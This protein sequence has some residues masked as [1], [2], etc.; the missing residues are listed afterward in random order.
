MAANPQVL[1]FPCQCTRWKPVGLIRYL[2]LWVWAPSMEKSAP[3]ITHPT[4]LRGP[5]LNANNRI[6]AS[7]SPDSR[8]RGAMGALFM[9]PF[10]TGPAALA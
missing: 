3:L 7:P 6:G 5:G 4:M 2:R 1:L 10:G 9:V 8:T